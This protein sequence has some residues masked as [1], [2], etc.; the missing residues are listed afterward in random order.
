MRLRFGRTGSWLHWLHTLQTSLSVGRMDRELD[1]AGFMFRSESLKLDPPPPPPPVLERL[2][3]TPKKKKNHFVDF[4]CN[5][6]EPQKTK[7]KV[8]LM[9]VPY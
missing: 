9:D 4:F 2:L 7:W 3:V 6:S 1:H 8:S 5:N